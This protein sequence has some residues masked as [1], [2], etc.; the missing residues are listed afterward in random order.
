MKNPDSVSTREEIIK[1]LPSNRLFMIK[2]FD[3]ITMVNI[4]WQ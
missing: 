1:I 4:L 2:V 3:E